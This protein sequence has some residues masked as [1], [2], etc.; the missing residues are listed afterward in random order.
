MTPSLVV[1]PDRAHSFSLEICLGFE[2]IRMLAKIRD[3]MGVFQSQ[4]DFG[5]NCNLSVL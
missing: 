5:L 1:L 4:R 2:E 3:L